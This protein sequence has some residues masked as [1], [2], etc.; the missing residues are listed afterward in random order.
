MDE[1]VRK[2]EDRIFE[3]EIKDRFLTIRVEPDFDENDKV[4]GTSV[5]G[6]EITERKHIERALE[7]LNATLEQRIEERAAL[8]D[9]R[10]RQLQKLAVE[11]IEAEENER[12]RISGLLHDDLQ[13]L[14]AGARMQVHAA[15]GAHPSIDALNEVERTLEKTIET[16]RDLSHDLT[17]PVLRHSDL[18]AAIEWLARQMGRKFGLSVRLE[19]REPQ[20]FAGTPAKTFLFRSVQELLFN[21]VKHA[22]TKIAEVVLSGS[23]Q[24]LAVTVGDRGRGFD[25]GIL[26]S[27]DKIGL[28]L[29]SLRERARYM[30]GDLTVESA[31]GEGSRFTLRIP[32]PLSEKSHFKTGMVNAEPEIVAPD[33]PGGGETIGES[34]YE[35]YLSA[36]L[37]GR[38]SVCGKI[39]QGLLDVHIDVKELYERL[40]RRSMYRVGELWE[41]NRITV[42]REHLATS[43]TE[44]LLNLVYPS[45][46]DIERI[47]K[48]AIVS[49]NANEFHQIGG[50]MVADILE[51]NGW[52]GHFLGANTPLDDLM[53]HIQEVKPDLAGMSLGVL[54]NMDNLKRTIEAVKSD[55]PNLDLL[56]GGQAFRR[57]GIDIVEQCKGAEYAS[58]LEQLERAIK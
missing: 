41:D 6:N 38:R 31:P 14:L 37:A 55:F 29:A 13:Q 52:D 33:K 20:R 57:G 49:C 4:A 7:E 27:S 58:S 40:F 50:K 42:A 24:G 56:V 17:P 23:E 1:A 30:G 18:V 25:P 8:A 10:A 16:V 46:F 36:L 53:R 12:K 32:D 39:V 28:G 35:N 34:V 54:S 3:I 43:I 5:F 19:T 51:L 45:I 47:G 44:S 2:R 11:L 48:K 9:S 26:S 22:G 15:S 21:A